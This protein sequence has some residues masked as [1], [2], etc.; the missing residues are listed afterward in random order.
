MNNK[1]KVYKWIDDNKGEV[2]TLLQ[3]LIKIPSVTPYFDED[4]KYKKEGEAQTFLKSYLDDMGLETEFTYP[5]AEKLKKYQ[6]KAG[7]YADHTFENR[8]NLV[9]K[10]RGTGNGKSILLSG[11]IDVV[12]RGSKWVHDPFGGIVKDGRLY[13]RGAVDMKGGI[14]SMV[15]ALK[16]ILESGLCL[17]GDAMV[18][19]VVDEEAGGM[20]TL[21]LVAEGY[22][23]DGCLITEPT[24]L[25]I[26]PLCR[27][28][29]WGKLIIE[30]RAGHIELKQGGFK[31]GG[32]VDAID[33]ASLYLEQFK[34]LNREWSVIK[35]H[36]YLPIPCQ[37]HIAQINAGEYPTTFA[38][39]AELTFNAQ[40]L[41]SEKDENGLGSKVKKE[42]ED[43][44]QA[45]ALTDPWLTENPPQ[46]EWLID[47]DC[48]ETKE[49]EAFF[50]TA[51][52]STQEVNKESI[53]EGI[54]CHTDM[55]W[56][57]NVGMPTINIGPG[58]PKLAHQADE[59]VEIDELIQCTKV[60]ASILMD[61][62]GVAEK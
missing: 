62:C 57:C 61:W 5:N 47:A 25:K 46:I 6:G 21:A 24:N 51:V 9:G 23:A 18:G 56:F 11:H 29:L 19:T 2:I 26:A 1:Q 15:G 30:G 45:V 39:H 52:S 36:K 40:Y 8:P 55:G 16:A 20:G 48:G 49:D 54:C 38:N 37:I 34:R 28:I 50:Q 14:A 22:R 53:V 59:Y 7:Y 60:I 42:L 43:F 3:D 13:G 10:A 44:V 17:K 41:P 12:Q 31:E 33:K 27:G 32:A 58:E 35:E 4:I